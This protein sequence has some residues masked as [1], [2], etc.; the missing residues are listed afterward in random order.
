MDTSR[1][2]IWT[3]AILEL[4]QRLPNVQLTHV[5]QYLWGAKAIKPTGLLHFNLCSFRRDLYRA[6]DANMPKPTE[7]AIGKEASRQFRTSQHKEYPNQFCKGL[8]LSIVQNLAHVERSRTFELHTLPL[9][10]VSWAQGAAKASS[11]LRRS[12]WLPDFQM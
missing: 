3:S 10:L 4:L 2:S 12:T 7:F 8:A 6:A 9:H 5:A 1:P 11:V